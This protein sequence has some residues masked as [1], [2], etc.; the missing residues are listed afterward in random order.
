MNIISLSPF[1]GS[2]LVLCF[3]QP[4]ILIT[5]PFKEI[6]DTFQGEVPV[7]SCLEGGYDTEVLL[8]KIKLAIQRTSFQVIAKCSVQCAK[9]VL[10]QPLELE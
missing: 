1:L 6:L 9:A 10:G 4:Y 3:G 5:M 2:G 8:K 7:V